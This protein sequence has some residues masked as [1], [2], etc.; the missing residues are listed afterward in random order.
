MAL[1]R[2]FFQQFH[3]SR[4]YPARIGWIIDMAWPR[5]REL[6]AD[7]PVGKQPAI[8]DTKCNWRDTSAIPLKEEIGIGQKIII[9]CLNA[10]FPSLGFIINAKCL[11]FIDRT[12][13]EQF[14]QRSPFRIQAAPSLAQTRFDE[15]SDGSLKTFRISH[16]LVKNVPGVG[17][18]GTLSFTF[19]L[20]GEQGPVLKAPLV[21]ERRECRAESWE[22]ASG[23][24]QSVELR[25]NPAHHAFP[26]SLDM[27]PDTIQGGGRAR[28]LK[29]D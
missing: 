18:V 7:C 2:G 10:G 15:L 14:K 20:V 12:A 3:H 13:T 24:P 16:Y 25:I 27:L 28:S 6:G 26:R 11:F 17:I 9:A 19:N 4:P 23:L 8:H 29:I 5:D 1:C 21:P 22:S